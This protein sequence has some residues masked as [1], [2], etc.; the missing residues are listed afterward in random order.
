MAE[1]QQLPPG[2]RL[3]QDFDPNEHMTTIKGQPYLTVQKRLIWFMRDQRY[4]IAERRATHPF[5]IRTELVEIQR[6]GDGKPIWAHFKTFVRDALG[7]EATMYGSE[8][9]K[10][11]PDCTEKAS[12]KSLGR[13]LAVMGYG[14]QYAPEI[15]EGDRLVD[16]PLPAREAAPVAAPVNAGDF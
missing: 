11:F 3:G 16:A 2:W 8:S 7:N 14:T 12:T 10:D 15:D 1:D 4:L 6:D 13:A 5:V 9:I